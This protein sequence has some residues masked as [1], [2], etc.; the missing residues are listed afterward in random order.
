M[1]MINYVQ[2]VSSP[3]SPRSQKLSHC[4]Q[5]YIRQGSKSPATEI[6]SDS[7]MQRVIPQKDFG[8]LL[9]QEEGWTI[10][11]AATWSEI[12]PKFT[13]QVCEHPVGC[14]SQALEAPASTV[15]PKRVT[16]ALATFFLRTQ[17]AYSHPP[18]A[19]SLRGL[20]TGPLAPIPVWSEC[21]IG[22]SS[23]A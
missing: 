2:E 7:L 1:Q 23:R 21:L 10:Y 20:R 22:L 19:R 18:P 11:P 16:A 9:N 17:P 5:T 13:Q 4:L 14:L 8:Q 3:L 15:I 6:N 12:A